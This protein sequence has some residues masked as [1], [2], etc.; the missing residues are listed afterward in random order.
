MIKHYPIIKPS[1]LLSNI[2]A[3]DVEPPLK[4]YT[5]KAAEDNAQCFQELKCI[6]QETEAEVYFDELNIH[7]ECCAAW[8]KL[9]NTYLGTGAKNTLAAQLDKTIQNIRY[10][11][12]KCGFTF[13]TNV[14]YHKTA[15]SL[16]WPWQKRPIIPP[17][18]LALGSIIF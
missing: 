12:S 10:N 3:T 18:T 9:Y 8:R 17:M 11:G 14:E 16:C 4:L 15:S 5:L 7:L 2:S 1:D 6:V 13:S